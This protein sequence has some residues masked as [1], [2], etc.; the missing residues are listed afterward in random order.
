MTNKTKVVCI[1]G[2]TASGKSDLAIEVAKDFN[3]EIISADS[4]QVY[5]NMDIGSNKVTIT[6]KD[7]KLYSENIRHHLID[8]ATPKEKFTVI[9]FKKLAQQ[10]IKKIK[11]RNHLPIIAGGTG[12]YI[13]ALIYDLKIPEVPPHPKIRE[14]LNK[15]PKEWLYKEL[16]EKDPKRVKEIHPNNKQRIIRALEII[17]ITGKPVPKND[18]SKS[19]Y[20]PLFI[21]LKIKRRNFKKRL[22]KRLIKRIDKGLMKEVKKLHK[23]GVSWQRLESFG[24]EY[25]YSAQYLQNKIS[26]EKM[27]EKIVTESYQYAKRQ[28][29]WFKRNKSIHWIK[30][31]EKDK[32]IK[33]IQ[34]FLK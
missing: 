15:K 23:N 8:I 1:V 33:L 22:K 30:Y 12:F 16:K 19:P 21:G 6:K 11:E 9:D 2:P 27:I 26:K 28:M 34:K 32:A 17:E 5:K 24:L 29:T 20:N 31:K 4:R 25:R 3:G 18:Y 13:D 14:R 7:G 10:A